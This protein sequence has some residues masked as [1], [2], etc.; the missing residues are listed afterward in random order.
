MI[1]INYSFFQ[2]DD[3]DAM[4]DVHSLLTD[5]PPP[6]GIVKTYFSNLYCRLQNDKIELFLLKKTFKS[7]SENILSV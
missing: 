5:V 6:S 7:N 1:F 2:I 3:T 4:E